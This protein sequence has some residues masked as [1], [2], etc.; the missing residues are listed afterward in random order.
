[1]KLSD[2][3]IWVLN[4]FRGF[5]Q[6]M[7]YKATSQIAYEADEMEHSMALML[8]GSFTGMPAPPVPLSLELLPVMGDSLE[9]LL[10][11]ASQTGNGLS[12]LAGIM[13]E[14]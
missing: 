9:K 5:G 1:M 7:N 6:A 13:G 8:F 3:F 14:P 11:R 12:E 10:L 4:F 2:M